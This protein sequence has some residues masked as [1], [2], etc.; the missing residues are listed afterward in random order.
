[1]VDFCKLNEREIN[2]AIAALANSLAE[3]LDEKEILL[4]SR[5]FSQLSGALHTISTFR[6]VCEHDKDQDKKSDDKSKK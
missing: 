5:I 4:L 6:A 3:G 2:F 1:M